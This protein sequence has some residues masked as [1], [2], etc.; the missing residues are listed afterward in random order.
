VSAVAVHN[1]RF[2]AGLNQ[3][4]LAVG[5][6]SRDAAPAAAVVRRLPGLEADPEFLAFAEELRA[7]MDSHGIAHVVD[8]DP[9]NRYLACALATTSLGGLSGTPPGPLGGEMTTVVTSSVFDHNLAW[10][11]DST[12]WEVPNRWQILCLIQPDQWKR[13]APTTLLPWS[14][15]LES[16]SDA[17]ADELA[18]VSY[19]WREQFPALRPLT[20][21]ILGDPPR[22]LR[23]ALASS[24]SG[25]DASPTPQLAEIDRAITGATDY[26]DIELTLSSI[27]VFDNH[28]VLHRGP[29][30]DPDGGRSLIRLKLGGLVGDLALA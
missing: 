25:P 20:A 3:S 17:A 11:T 18:R 30:L 23:P 14:R 28:A 9:P 27:L 15:V 29:H 26:V 16:V 22:W 5:G 1:V 8:I 24:L 12:S 6:A 21:P 10:H 13:P 7:A 4:L 19:P 2:P